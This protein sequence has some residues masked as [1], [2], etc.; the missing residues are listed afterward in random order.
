M[1]TVCPE[2]IVRA[3]ALARFGSNPQLISPGS[4]VSMASALIGPVPLCSTLMFEIVAYNDSGFLT[5]VIH[6]QWER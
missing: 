3:G 4:E 5:D 2:E 6:S 1:H